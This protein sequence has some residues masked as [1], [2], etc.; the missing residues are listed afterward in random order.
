MT[1]VYHVPGDQHEFLLVLV[2]RDAKSR[3]GCHDTVVDGQAM[4]APSLDLSRILSCALPPTFRMLLIKSLKHSDRTTNQNKTGHHIETIC[5]IHL[6]HCSSKSLACNGHLNII[7]LKIFPRTALDNL[8]AADVA[9]VVG[10]VGCVEKGA[11]GA[12][13]AVPESSPLVMA[14]PK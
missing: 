1:H 2:T 4:P 7:L 12:I 6:P 13:A 5:G 9:P 11:G 3:V 10:G 8:H 14:P